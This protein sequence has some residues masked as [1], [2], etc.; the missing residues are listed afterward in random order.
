MKARRITR[1][2]FLAVALVIVVTAIFGAESMASASSPT[3]SKHAAALTGVSCSSPTACTAVGAYYSEPPLRSGSLIVRWNGRAWRREHAPRIGPPGI[4]A[5]DVSCPTPRRCIAVGV[6]GALLWNGRSWRKQAGVTGNAVSCPSASF[7]EVVEASGHRLF[8]ESW[9]DGRWAREIMRRPT[10]PT[11]IGSVTLAGVS[12]TSPRFCM[13]V[14]DYS[15]PAEAQPSAAHRDLT[16]AERW[17]GHTWRLA[18]PADPASLAALKAVSCRSPGFCVAVGTQRARRPLAARWTG[19]AWQVQATPNPSYVGYST[20]DAVACPNEH[21]CEAVGDE[22]GE[23][24]LA[25]AWRTDRWSP[26]RVGTPR[27]GMSSL[28]LSCPSAI[29]CVLVG[30]ADGS[31]M[32]ETWDG[33]RWTIRRTPS[34]VK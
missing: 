9:E 15:F 30:T 25:E 32:S 27:S 4:T 5:V 12:C 11:P 8:S 20:L 13:A 33:K 34:P 22:N 17:N 7:C 10:A 23:S 29:A 28:A 1:C 31:P 16:L 2:V 6:A 26:Q 14:G 19:T 24:L 21:S 3:P 18:P